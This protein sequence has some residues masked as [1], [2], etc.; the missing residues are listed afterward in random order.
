MRTRA[1]SVPNNKQGHRIQRERV[2]A[3][4]H[5]WHSPERGMSESLMNP[6]TVALRLRHGACRDPRHFPR[7]MPGAAS[8]S[9][10]QVI[11]T[12]WLTTPHETGPSTTR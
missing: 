4:T 7:C 10:V 1:G 5:R 6:G 9:R 3:E 2:F 8:R 11:L 12:A